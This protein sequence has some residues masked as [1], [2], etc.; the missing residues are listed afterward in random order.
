MDTT[1]KTWDEA[2]N[3]LARASIYGNLGLFVGTGFSMAVMEKDYGPVPLS[4]GSLIEAAASALGT[5]FGSIHQ[6]GRS[7][8]E[9]A[10]AVC[11]E[12]ARSREIKFGDACMLLKNEVAQL[13]SWYPDEKERKEFSDLLSVIAPSWIITTNYDLVI[14]S[15]LTGRCLSLGPEDELLN[16][17][18]VVPVYH[19]HGIRTD[20]GRIVITR[21]QRKMR[22]LRLC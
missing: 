10:T 7:Y 17:A 3:F 15:L 18:G 11:A 6:A 9:I 19:L 1:P 22:F 20:P 12:L 4:W 14:E 2:L 16:P 5:N 8:P 21:L 13:T